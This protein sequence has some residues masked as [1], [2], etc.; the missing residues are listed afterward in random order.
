MNW[1]VLLEVVLGIATVVGAGIAARIS[2]RSTVKAAQITVDAQAFTRAKAIY[3]SSIQELTEQSARHEKQ[4]TDLVAEV[5][6][7]RVSVRRHEAR[8]AQLEGTLQ[9]HRIPVPPWPAMANLAL[10]RDESTD[11]N[12]PSPT[13]EA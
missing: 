8:V 9:H 10:V 4:I 6:T 12:R 7:L 5:S 13:T 3:E 2:G 11:P 1:Q